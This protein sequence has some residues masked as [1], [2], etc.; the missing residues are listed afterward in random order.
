M[1]GEEVVQASTLAVVEMDQ[2]SY[3]P[4]CRGV[5]AGPR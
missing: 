4:L 3:H 5:G 2:M 1:K